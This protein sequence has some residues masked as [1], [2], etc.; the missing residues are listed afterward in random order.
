M[1]KIITLTFA[2]I[3]PSHATVVATDDFSYAD[4]PLVP[5]GGWANQSGTAGTA[6]VSSGQVL[7]SQ[8]S[9]SEDVELQFANDLVSGV[10][11]ASFD[12]SVTAPGTIGGGDFEYFAHFSNDTE[13]NF[14]A[15]IDI[16]SPTVS[17]DYTIGLATSSSTNEVALPVD[18]SFGAVVPVTLEFNIDTGLASVTAGGQ[19][20]TSVAPSL[21]ET[22]DSFNFRQSN[23]SSDETIAI[24]NLS[25]SVIPEPSTVLLG[26]LALLGFLRRKR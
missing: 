10:V 26:G 2:A 9:G 23:S 11:S 13:F 22:I 3:V 19:T 21:G 16:V 1:K 6:L 7:I 4:G 8:D 12:I 5:N 24:D 17:G 15:R 20:V 25:V 14:R 18:F